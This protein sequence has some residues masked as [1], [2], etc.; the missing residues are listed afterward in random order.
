MSSNTGHPAAAE[1]EDRAAQFL[2]SRRF[3]QWA[4]QEQMELD[5]WLAQSLSHRV[6]F[7]RLEATLLRTDRLAALQSRV[8]PRAP[9]SPRPN[10]LGLK[11]AAIVSVVTLA[12]LGSAYLF[13]GD[14]S[15]LYSTPLGGHEVLSLRDGSTIELNTNTAVRI[16]ASQ[17]SAILERGEAYFQITHDAEHPFVLKASGHVVTDLGTKFLVRSAGSELTVSLVEGMAR[18]EAATQPSQRALLTPGDV[19]ITRG[20]KIDV[21]KKQPVIVEEGLGWRHGVI[22]FDNTTLADAAAEFNRYNEVKL[23]VADPQIA[24]M[25]I[26]AT[27]P[28]RDVERFA[29]AAHVL[30]G[31]RVSK[32]GNEVLITR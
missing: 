15:K 7:W 29:R 14:G 27:F 30:L 28:A 12:G 3:E 10:R 24:R 17:R 25:K 5:A 18:I 11:V 19:A 23:V 6:A 16:D 32:K 22:V 31:V 20:D 13:S 8:S 21:R 2:A 1:I 9:A 4:E 26:G